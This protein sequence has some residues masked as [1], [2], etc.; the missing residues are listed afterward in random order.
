VIIPRQEISIHH[1]ENLLQGSYL[2]MTNILAIDTSTDACSVALY[3]SGQYSELHEIIPRQ[4]NQRLFSMLRELLPDGNLRAQGVDAIAY[5]NGPGSFTGL[6]IAASAVQG[7]AFANDL[8]AIPVSTLACQTQ[9]ALR[10]G[11][12]GAGDT[13]LSLLDARISE[14]Y[15]GLYKFEE[16]LATAIQEPRVSSPQAIVVEQQHTQLRAVGGGLRYL[17]SLPSTLV[18]TVNIADEELLPSARDLIPLAIAHYALGHVQN[19][20]HVAPLY[21]REEVSWKKI[22]EQGKPQ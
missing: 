12:V 1:G 8:P 22:S 5:A 4:H 16:R 18:S 19:A 9:T 3:M 7:L 2:R 15:W 11:L 21:V 14:V 17:D 13:V 20:V 6:R 10:T